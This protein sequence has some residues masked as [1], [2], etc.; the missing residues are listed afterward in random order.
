[1][2]NNDKSNLRLFDGTET[3]ALIIPYN[4]QKFC[5][6]HVEV[7]TGNGAISTIKIRPTKPF[8]KELNERV[9]ILLQASIENSLL[10]ERSNLTSK[11]IPKP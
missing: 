2:E 7:Q 10:N 9:F 5:H 4:I 11:D 6:S 8:L 1:M 3:P